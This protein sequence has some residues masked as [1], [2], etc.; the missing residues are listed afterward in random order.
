[1]YDQGAKMNTG[2][3]QTLKPEPTRQGQV[4]E[5]LERGQSLGEKLHSAIQRLGGRLESIIRCEPTC[6]EDSPK[7]P[8]DSVGLAEI[9]REQNRKTE[10]AIERINS[11]IER[12]EL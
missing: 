5:Q 2:L 1:M 7:E 12:C 4:S 9:L 10:Y 6:G 8:C 11:L 3:S